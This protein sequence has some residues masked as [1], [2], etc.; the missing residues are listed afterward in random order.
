MGEGAH[1]AARMEACFAKIGTLGIVC[2]E[3]WRSL[4][5]KRR[6]I[7]ELV[8]T[9]HAVPGEPAKRGE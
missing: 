4:G 7:V 2:K 6:R 1:D 3:Q 5:P 9:Q 8:A